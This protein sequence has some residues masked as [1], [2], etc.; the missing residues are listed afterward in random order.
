[1]G[2]SRRRGGHFGGLGRSRQLGALVCAL[3]WAGALACGKT[4]P[5]DPAN[6]AGELRDTQ[7][8]HEPCEVDA[9]SAVGEDVNGDNRPDLRIV[10]DGAREVCRGADL[11]F[12]GKVDVWT[13]LDPAGAV[14]R[15]ES[16]FDRDGRIDD[17]A[18]Y[19]GGELFE[20]QRATSLRGRLDTWQYYAKGKLTRAVRDSDG[21]STIDE[22]WEYPRAARPDCP[23]VHS[24]ADHDGRPDPGSTVNLCSDELEASKAKSDEGQ[25]TDQPLKPREAMPVELGTQPAAQGSTAPA[26]GQP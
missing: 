2:T 25:D 5:K 7:I 8:V 19:R 20:R 1:M 23:L 18:L 13:Y 21:D 10:K 26:G 6:G 9:G 24:D 4:P 22:W 15:R 11:N 17:I 14:R 12:D 3:L 16:D